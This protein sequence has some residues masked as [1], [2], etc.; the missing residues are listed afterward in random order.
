MK[1]ILLYILVCLLLL[2][3]CAVLEAPVQD[4]PAPVATAAPTPVPTPTPRPTTLWIVADCEPEQVEGFFSAADDVLANMRQ[5]GWIVE[6]YGVDGFSNPDAAACD[7]VIALRT[8]SGSDISG[9][10]AAA[11]AGVP[12]ALAD[13]STIYQSGHVVPGGVS[14][15]SISAAEAADFTLLE[16]IRF[17]P[18]DTP[19]RMI[20]LFSAEDSIAAKAFFDRVD[21]G[22]ILKKSVYYETDSE[23]N[24]EEYMYSV[25]EAYVAGLIDAIYAE[26]MEL[27]QTALSA[28]KSRSR[29]D[30]DVFCVPSGALSEQAQYLQKWYF[31]LAFGYDLESVGAA[32]AQE[33]LRMLAG[34]EPVAKELMLAKKY[35][36]E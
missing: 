27:A 31:P 1:R 35:Y 9:L 33:L 29:D 15:A 18:H 17:P 5:A 11:N 26:N 20:G 30:I 28:L 8:D 6:T 4:T 32:Q 16:A 3:G 19:V 36:E 25:L 24:A 7:G 10:S 34:G 12:V 14:Y 2:C 22:M 23:R 13:V 21:R